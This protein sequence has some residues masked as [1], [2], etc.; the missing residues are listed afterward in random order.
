M[1][2]EIPLDIAT[3]ETLQQNSDKHHV[4]YCVRVVVSEIHR[5]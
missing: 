1:K 4:A 5:Y 2:S 3:F